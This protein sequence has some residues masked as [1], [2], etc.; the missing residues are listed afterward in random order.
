M[1]EKRKFPRFPVQETVVCS[2]YGRQMTMRT[3]NI[4]MGG[5][6]LETGFDLGVG[7]PMD[8]AILANGIRIQ[9]KGRILAIEEFGNKVKARLCFAPPSN[10][11]H[12]KLLN[13]VHA[14]SRRPPQRG[15]VDSPASLLGGTK[16]YALM[17]GTRWVANMFKNRQ[18]DRKLQMVNSWLALLT[19][20]ER[21]VITLRFGFGGE[22]PLTP[23]ST[24]KRLGLHPEKVH[25]IEAAAIEKLRKMS[26][27]KEIDLDDII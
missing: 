16:R 26:K 21:T 23:E 1:P 24:G 11:E 8:F 6:K 10:W 13:Y 7:E 19:D 17:R 12:R 4:S 15:V 18:D 5:L 25:Q 14:L 9:C 3:L 20:M 2:R 27:K 22:D